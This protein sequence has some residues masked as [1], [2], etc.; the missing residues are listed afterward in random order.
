VNF[1]EL[2]KP[3]ASLEVCPFSALYEISPDIF[4]TG[5]FTLFEILPKYHFLRESFAEEHV[6]NLSPVILKPS[7]TFLPFIY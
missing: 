4:M 3:F 6:K 1:L 7:F 2:T 5:F